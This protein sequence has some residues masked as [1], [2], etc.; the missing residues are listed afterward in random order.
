MPISKFEKY[1]KNRENMNL[2]HLREEYSRQAL[3]EKSVDASPFQQ[4]SKWFNEAVEAKVKE[5]NA[6]VLSTVSADG[7]PHGRVVL[8]KGLENEAFVFFTNY[9]S[10]KGKDLEGN[11]K[12]SLTFFW[13]DLE[14]QLR[15]EGVVSKIS[16]QVSTA[17][18]QS[19]PVGSQIG[20]WVSQ[21]SDPVVDRQTLEDKMV[22]L[23]ARFKGQDSI[24]KPPHWGG[25]QLQPH[26]MEFWQGR[27]SRLHDR[28]VYEAIEKGVWMTKRLSP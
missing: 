7:Q 6:M 26:R 4:F 3:D 14:R 11:N 28:I 16:E 13:A 9:Q 1:L 12:A 8:L 24:P 2:A 27:Q 25:Y 21:Q 20:A 17:Y 5:P 23:T 10:H 15:I 18:F 22:E 19:R